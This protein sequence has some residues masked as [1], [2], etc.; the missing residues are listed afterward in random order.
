MEYDVVVMLEPADI[1]AEGPGLYVAM[2]RPTRQLHVVHAGEL[3]RG[4]VEAVEVEET[5][6]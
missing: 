4:L 3:P 5:E 1:L 2:T 6:E